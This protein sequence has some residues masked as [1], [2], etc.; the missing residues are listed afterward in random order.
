L[1]ANVNRSDLYLE[2][3]RQ[4]TVVFDGAMGT[5]IQDAGLSAGDFGGKE[6]A[7]DYLT[8]TRPDLI[9]DIHRGYLE[10]GADVLETNSFQAS[11]LKLEEWGL[12]EATFEINSEAARLAREAADEYEAPGRPR[13]VAGSMGPTGMLPSGNDPT[14]SA[15]GFAELSDIF[16]RQAQGL[17]TGGADLL[18]IETMQDILELRAAI[19]GS[20]LAFELAGR[21]VPIQAQVALDVTGR[22]LLGTDIA[23][24]GTILRAMRADVIGL[25]CSVGPEHLREPVRWLCENVD[26]PVSVIPNAGMP[27]NVDGQARYPMGPE[28]MASRLSAFVADFGANVVGGCCG[29]TP[30]HI[31]ALTEAVGEAGRKVRRPRPEPLVASAMRAVSLDQRPRPLIVGERVNTQGSRRVKELVLADDYDGVLQVAREQVDGGAHVLDVC[32]ALTERPDE[33]EQLRQVTKRLSMG[34]EAPLMIDTLEL[35]ALEAALETSPGRSIINSI[36]MENG[37]GRI[38]AVVPLAVRHGAAVVALT[39][40]EQGMAK[41]A[42]EKLRVARAIHRICVGEYGLRPEDLI[43]DALTFTLATGEEEWRRSAVETLDG[44]REIK[45][46]LPGV[47][48]SLGVSNL[49]F[50]LPPAARAVLNSVFLQHA[51]EA[52]LD[53][54]MV[55]PAHVLGASE[56]SA[57]ER[58]LAEDLIFDRQEDALP[59]LIGHFENREQVP[60]QAAADRF[61]DTTVDERIHLKILH[62]VREG[63]EDD[64]DSALDERGQRA[65]DEA[66]DV[67][68]NVLLPAMKDVGD[69]FGAGELILPFVLQSAEVMKRAVAHLENYLDVAEGHT[70]GVVVLATVFGDVHDIGKNLVGTI[71]ANNG[72][73]VH[74]LGRQVPVNAIIDKAL[75]VG[76]DAIGLSALLVSTSK[77]MPLCLAELALRGLDY[78]VLVGGAAINRSFGRRIT[79]LE[80]GTPYDGGLFY[81]RDAFEGLDTMEAIVVPETRASLYAE[82]VAEA[83]EARDEPRR[84]VARPVSEGPGGRE[85]L[86][87]VAVPTPAFLGVRPVEGIDPAEMFASMDEKSLYKLSWGG[88][89]VRGDAWTALLRDDFEPRRRRMEAESVAQGWITPRACYGFFRAAAD[90]EDLVILEDDGAGERGRF[91]FPRQEGHDRLCIADYFHELE[92]DDG[93]DVVALQ[94]VTVGPA[95]TAHVDA[96]QAAGEYSEAFFAH[97]LAV[98]AAEGLAEVVHGRVLADLGLL[99]GHGRRYSWGYPACPDLEAHELAL[100]LLGQPAAALGVELTE[101]YQFVPEQTTIAI[102]VHHP[103]AIYFSARRASVEARTP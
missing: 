27:V 89:G 93:P 77:Q 44:I 57:E 46:E 71:L 17:I 3:T 11:S 36:N 38:E 97:G 51:V 9:G 25:N 18:I 26:R 79:F 96:L 81:C 28:E 84:P 5:M 55:N 94:L 101:A 39:I 12:D 4:R 10:A 80:D 91:S 42:A 73:T 53:L 48:T 98:E 59:R 19:H 40:D 2:L 74:D 1:E 62:R 14:L 90:G 83:E 32:V 92:D 58:T 45:R 67:L 76:A 24:V 54:A 6:G 78:P 8:L 63:I 47:W 41:T 95:A 30:E 66:V 102:V 64:I 99:S 16:C 29:T 65:N 34:V 49:S 31:E 87:R 72:F 52:G 75:E 86:P 13:F 21:R 7:N 100:A 61:A 103:S 50:G 22:M 37:R 68:N 60:A 69:R 70:K 43:F 23:A 33:A 82:R 20:R 15:I 88:K 85:K 56:I 35:D